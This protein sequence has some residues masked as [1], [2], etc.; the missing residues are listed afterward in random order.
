MTIMIKMM[1]ISTVFSIVALLTYGTGWSQGAVATI[2][3]IIEKDGRHALL[4]NGQPFFMLAGQAH[5]SSAWQYIKVGEG[6]YENGKFK[7][8][9]IRNG[10]ETDWG[11]TRIGA[12]PVVLHTTLTTR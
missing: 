12:T 2:P 6:R 10:D 8:L 11:G 9:R 3:K 7:L 5:N 1:R 4:V